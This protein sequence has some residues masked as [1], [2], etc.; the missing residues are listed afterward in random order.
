M[1][2]TKRYLEKMWAEHGHCRSQSQKGPAALFSCMLWVGH[3][4]DHERVHKSWKTGE[5]Y[6]PTPE[7]VAALETEESQY[8]FLDDVD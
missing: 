4:G 7:E 5:G 6:E 2:V 1:S 3:D 8:M